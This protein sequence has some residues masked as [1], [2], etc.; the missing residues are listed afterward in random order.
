M[1]RPAWLDTDSEPECYRIRD[2]ARLMSVCTETVRNW[3]KGGT[4]KAH[5]V[6]P[7]GTT[8]LI[9]RTDVED[10]LRQAEPVRRAQ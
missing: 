4:L 9:K 1:T 6:G 3:I 5:R 8:V 10:L 7:K 2:V